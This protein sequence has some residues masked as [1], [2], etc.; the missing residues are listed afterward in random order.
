MC[1]R[2]LLK[3]SC[4]PHRS[5]HPG[6]FP[7]LTPLYRYIE[8]MEPYKAKA[9]LANERRILKMLNGVLTDLKQS[10][11][12]VSVD[13]ARLT[14]HDIGLLLGWMNGRGLDVNTKVKYLNYMDVFLK[15]CG[16]PVVSNIRSK[17]LLPRPVRSKEIRCLSVEDVRS[18]FGALDKMD[19]WHEEIMRFVIPFYYYTGLRPGELRK[20]RV[21]DL[22]TVGWE[23]VVRHP[24]GE[25]SWGMERTV[26]VASPLRSVVT[27][28]LAERKRELE[29][30]GKDSVSLIPCS[31]HI[32]PVVGCYAFTSFNKYR[33]EVE[34]ISG[35]KF[36]LK[37]LRTTCGQHLKDMD[38][39]IEAISK[40]LGHAST[41]TTETYYARMKDEHAFKIIEEAWNTLTA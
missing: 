12:I 24:K 8:E 26:P 32:G 35:V 3:T 16:N 28:F 19:G 36:T 39:P 11:K 22:D 31:Q 6:R 37:M 29:R 2:E 38:V 14:E 1:E 9:T 30:H 40:L 10:G 25:G 27:R 7:F 33:L 41:V 17:R 18:I 4:H 23:L 15:W 34:E 21:D 5:K 20:A 13:P